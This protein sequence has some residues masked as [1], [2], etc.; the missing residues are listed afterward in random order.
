MESNAEF[1][2]WAKRWSCADLEIR[3]AAWDAWRAREDYIAR[4]EAALNKIASW[5]E[6]QEVG[7]HF[8][9]PNAAAI[10]RRAL[11]PQEGKG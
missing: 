10:A 1:R 5:P 3:L 6:G 4:L 7:S 11:L 8:D 9:E 2:A